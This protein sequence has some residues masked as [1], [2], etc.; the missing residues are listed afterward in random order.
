MLG[1]NG[2]GKTTLMR[3]SI[4]LYK[5]EFRYHPGKWQPGGNPFST[6]MPS[7]TASAWS[8]SIL[9]WCRRCSV[10]ENVVLGYTDSFVL[11]K[12]EIEKKVAEAAERFGI[13]VDP[14]ALVRHLSV[15]QRQRVEILKALYRN[16]HVL[17]LDEPTAVLVPQE[18][19]VLFETLNRLKKEGLA[20]V[21]ISHKLHEVT[22]ITDRVTVLRDGKVHRHGFGGRRDPEPA[23]ADDGRA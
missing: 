4:G 10:A 16:A 2:A 3:I 8:P 9:P 20:I 12:S 11:N 5:A 23:G 6:R 7:P 1:E 15:G 13:D 21:F 18:V 19:D 14:T 22:Q 17:I